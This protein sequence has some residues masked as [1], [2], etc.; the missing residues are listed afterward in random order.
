[1]ATISKANLLAT[2]QQVRDNTAFR[3]FCGRG[4]LKTWHAPD[5]TIIETFR[6][7]L[8]AETQRKLANLMS[9]Q[10]VRLGYANPAK[11]DIDST[12]QE[13]NI[14]YPALVNLLIKVAILTKAVAGKY[15]PI[16]RAIDMLS[17]RGF[18]KYTATF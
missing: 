12:A 9:Q 10:A 6:S 5:H 18:N 16:R 17:W 3:L 1:M 8:T 2:I 4:L 13:A 15:W 11:L 14:A 7:R